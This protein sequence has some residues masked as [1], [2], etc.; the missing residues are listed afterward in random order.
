MITISAVE[1]GEG[2]IVT[3]KFARELQAGEA[4]ASCVVVATVASGADPSPQDIVFGAPDLSTAG[5]VLHQIRPA[6]DGTTYKVKATATLSTG[7]KLVRVCLLP[8]VS[9]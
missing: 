4:I 1:P 5:V 9:A 2:I 7:R 8:T 6:V 3:F